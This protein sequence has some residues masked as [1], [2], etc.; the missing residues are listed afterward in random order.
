[1]Q[2]KT[3]N[4]IGV[5]EYLLVNSV[6]G[7]VHAL[8]GCQPLLVLRPTG[9]ITA[10]MI[11]M[12]GYA[13]RFQIPFG[14]Y[15]GATGIFIGLYMT[16]IASCELSRLIKHLSRFTHEIFACFVCSLY[17]MDGLSEVVAGFDGGEREMG[18]EQFG[19]ALYSVLIACA[20]FGMAIWLHTAVSWASFNATIRGLLTDY[21]VAASIAAITLL[22]LCW[23]TEQLRFTV[24]R[25][26]MP[27]SF[28]PTCQHELT[29]LGSNRTTVARS[30]ATD[31][32]CSS[33]A[34]CAFAN[35][36][37]GSSP[38]PWFVYGVGSRFLGTTPE[39]WLV[40]ALSAVPIVIFFYFDQNLSSLLTQQPE[41]QMRL[42]SFYN[43]SF[44]WMGLLN[45]VGPLFGLP[46]VTGSLPH[47]PQLAKALTIYN[48]DAD[49]K[50]KIDAVVENRLAPF[51]M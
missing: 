20:V 50:A 28:R 8:L 26:D 9:P 10:I 19:E 32:S 34:H 33:R 31:C 40:A 46:F 45:I 44:L 36:F 30:I 42:G 23:S 25:L 5:A 12:S 21:A 2:K 37:T 51:L 17:V 27:D 1:M 48:Y 47:S 4:R 43:S 3:N 38:R 24:P 16:T 29:S 15:L 14:E 11:M 35:N 49:Q 41:M 6:G 13:D 22:T 18:T 7:M 39:T